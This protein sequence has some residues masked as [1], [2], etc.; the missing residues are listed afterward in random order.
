MTTEPRT[1][2][3]PPTATP[4]GRPPV[5]VRRSYSGVEAQVVDAAYPVGHGG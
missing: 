2:A 1:T 3:T 4:P 5:G